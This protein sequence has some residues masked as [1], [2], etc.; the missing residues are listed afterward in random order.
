M[1]AS[2]ATQS[3][4]HA[5]RHYAVAEIAERWNLSVDKVREL[6]ADE[7]GSGSPSDL[8][9]CR[10]NFSFSSSVSSL[11]LSK[12]AVERFRAWQSFANDSQALRTKVSSLLGPS[13]SQSRT[14]F[15]AASQ[16]RRSRD[17][18]IHLP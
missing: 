18:L 2:L 7:P 14:S 12:E 9:G 1:G 15:C 17:F 10:P 11:Y 4:L 8:I 16:F 5:E 13:A 3:S 6:F